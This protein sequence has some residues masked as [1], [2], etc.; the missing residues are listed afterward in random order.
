MAKRRRRRRA[1]T[2]AP[3]S[4]RGS[5]AESLLERMAKMGHISERQFAAGMAV[6]AA[7]RDMASGPL[8]SVTIDEAP[9]PDDG[10]P[11]TYRVEFQA[12][13]VDRSRTLDRAFLAAAQADPEGAAVLIAVT[14]ADRT[15]RSLD[16]DFAWRNGRAAEI[17]SKVLSAVADAGIDMRKKQ[18]GP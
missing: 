6:A 15:C 10:R 7:V 11:Q 2:A 9:M 13:F 16:M 8:A 5:T 12:T 4:P 18:A 17:L 14:L 1:R 3:P